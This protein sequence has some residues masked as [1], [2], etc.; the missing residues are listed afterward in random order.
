MR[1]TNPSKLI[2]TKVTVM[3]S[4]AV[5]DHTSTALQVLAISARP[6]APSKAPIR[7]LL[8]MVTLSEKTLIVDHGQS[9]YLCFAV[10]EVGTG[11]LELNLD[12]T[13]LVFWKVGK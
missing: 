6:P 4:Y 2:L 1:E 13:A 8:Q 11:V 7:S 3:S 12:L 5:G 9:G 10:S